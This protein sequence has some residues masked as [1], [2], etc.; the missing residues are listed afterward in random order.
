[1]DMVFRERFLQPRAWYHPLFILGF[2]LP[3]MIAFVQAGSVV[4]TVQDNQGVAVKGLVVYLE[5]VDRKIPVANKFSAIEISQKD[6]GFSPYLSVVQSGTTVTFSNRDDI[7]HH[8]YSVSGNARFSYTLRAGEVTEELLIAAPGLIA[9]GCNIHDWMSGYVLVL[10]TPF[11]ALSDERGQANF[12][13][14]A[15]GDYRVVLWHPQLKEQPGKT[16]HLP[17]DAR[18]LL[19]LV[20]DMAKIPQQKGV[21]DFDFLEGYE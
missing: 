15:Q 18:V 3:G 7:T 6:K 5:P 4:V 11:Y 1:M 2:C 16:I 9:M 12:V 8:I 10:N 21:D 17:G 20:N 14:M 13:A 19:Q